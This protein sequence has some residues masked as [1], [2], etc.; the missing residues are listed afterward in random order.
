MAKIYAHGIFRHNQGAIGYWAMNDYCTSVQNQS[1]D[2][3]AVQ[4]GEEG[5]GSKV[6]WYLFCFLGGIQYDWV[7]LFFPV[8][9][10]FLI[11]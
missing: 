11:F 6:D 5:Q 4:P 8:M 1:T 10:T 3:G 7:S 2:K 9:F